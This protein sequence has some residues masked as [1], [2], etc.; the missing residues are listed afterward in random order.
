MSITI[1][2]ERYLKKNLNKWQE[3]LLFLAIIN[4]STFFYVILGMWMAA[5]HYQYLS[6]TIALLLAVGLNF[7]KKHS[8]IIIISISFVIFSQGFYSYWR[9][10][11]ESIR[12]YITDIGYQEIFQIM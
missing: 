3:I 11:S 7:Q 10:S 8:K 6:P 5:H 9:A 1:F 12:P 2:K 4:L